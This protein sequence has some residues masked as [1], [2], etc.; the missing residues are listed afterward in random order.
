[1]SKKV[2]G[3]VVKNSQKFSEVQSIEIRYIDK[4]GIPQTMPLTTF[5]QKLKL[6]IYKRNDFTEINP[7]TF[8]TTR[9]DLI[10]SLYNR[11]I[12]E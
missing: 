11:I 6:S 3:D 5:K 4:F 8:G 2:W 9:E 12:T 1:M 10:E 7:S